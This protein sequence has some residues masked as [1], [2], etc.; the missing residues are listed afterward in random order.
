MRCGGG[1]Y[2]NEVGWTL[3]CVVDVGLGRDDRQSTTTYSGGAPY[4]RTLTL[5]VPARCSM[6]LTDSFGDGWNG[7]TWTGF[8]QTIQMMDGTQQSIS[9]TLL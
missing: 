3:S 4:A 5:E 7:A 1:E 2:D 9:F 8:G 6:S